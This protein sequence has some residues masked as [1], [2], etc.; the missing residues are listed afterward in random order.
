MTDAVQ[1]WASERVRQ[2]Y[3]QNDWNCARSQLVLQC[4]AAQIQLPP[5]WAEA[6]AGLHGAGGYGAQCGLVEGML[7]FLGLKGALSEE[8]AGEIS[9]RCRSFASDFEARFGSL[10]CRQLRPQG[11]PEDGPPHACEAL[12]VQAVV[13]A[14]QWLLAEKL[15]G[16]MD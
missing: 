10:L 7:V 13:F 9:E 12:T 2:C 16:E 11:F 1:Q 14:R 5:M 15:H 3:W 4:E 8:T 6:M